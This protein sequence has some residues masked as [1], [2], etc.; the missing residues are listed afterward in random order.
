MNTITPGV[1]MSQQHVDAVTLAGW[2]FKV[3]P[4]NG[5][6]PLT[7]HGHKDFSS[8]MDQVNSWWSKW[9]NANIGARVF[10]G[11]V[12]VDIDPRNGGDATWKELNHGRELPDTLTTRTGSGGLHLWYRLPHAD[13]IKGSAGPG[14]DLKTEAG[15]LVMPGSYHPTTGG[16]YVCEKWATPAPLPRWLHRHVYKPKPQPVTILPSK[17]G[18]TGT[19]LVKTVAEAQPGQRNQVLFWAACRNFEEN[20]NIT[21]ELEEAARSI[22]LDDAEIQRTLRSAEQSVKEVAA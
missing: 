11:H 8:N 14:I 4:L 5:K 15:Y 12:V 21:P 1:D 18:K 3:G 7:E 2:G 20:L 16:L 17:S 9:P 6:I 13:M 10:A 22:G 19:G